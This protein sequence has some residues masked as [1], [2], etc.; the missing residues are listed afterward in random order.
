MNTLLRAV[1]LAAPVVAVGACLVSSCAGDGD[2]PWLGG[3]CDKD[4]HCHSDYQNIPGTICIDERCECQDPDYHICCLPSEARDS[5]CSLA[6]RPCSEC[7]AGTTGCEGVGGVDTGC[8]SDAECPGPPSRECGAGRCVEG[9]CTVEIHV[10]PIVSQ[11]R[12]DCRR[13]DCTTAGELLV[14]DDPS[15]VYDDGEQCTYDSCGESGPVNA[16]LLEAAACPVSREGMCHAG[17]CVACFA[18]D[19]TMNDC[20]NGL[21]C[22]D[23]LCVPFHCVNDVADLALGETARDCGGLCRPCIV[24]EACRSSAD[25]KSNVCDAARCAPATCGDGVKNGE[26]TG[27]D[28][29]ATPCPSCAAGQGCRTD[30]SCESGVCWAG[31]CQESSCTDGVKNAGEDGVDCGGGCAPCP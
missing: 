6:C 7:A 25:C 22:L 21:A 11:R 23:V 17:A 28:C 9:Q 12:G 4:A 18:G 24:G 16:P 19:V 2:P 13:M 5:K 27:I 15:D 8:Q 10:G 29:G 3:Y 14:L 31:V 26:E 30:A 1:V 20:P